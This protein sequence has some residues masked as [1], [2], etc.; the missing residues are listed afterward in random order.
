MSITKTCIEGCYILRYDKKLDDRGSFCRVAC[1]K[2]LQDEG[3]SFSAL[4]T[5]IATNK[6]KGTIRG[7]HYQSYPF[8]EGKIM[9]CMLGSAMLIVVDMR[10]ESKTYLNKESIFISSSEDSMWSVYVP[11]YCATG[12]QTTEDNTA[13][14]YMID[15]E[16]RASNSIGI[17]YLDKT[18][19]IPWLSIEVTISERDRELPNI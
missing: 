17:N 3:V 1:C 18:L 12:Y 10:K 15:E 8:G 2:E 9:T 14:L 5:S 11:K 16:Y 13:I 6:S 19:S 7:L 4:Q